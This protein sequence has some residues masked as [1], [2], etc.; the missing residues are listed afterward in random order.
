VPE[1]SVWQQVDH[2]I[3]AKT[4]AKGYLP[5][6]LDS[7]ALVCQYGGI[8]KIV[9][10]SQAGT[11]QGSGDYKP[12]GNNISEEVL[13]LMKKKYQDYDNVRE[14]YNEGGLCIF[15]FEGLGSNSGKGNSNLFPDG[16][17]GAMMVVAIGDEVQFVTKQAST[18]PAVL[19]TKSE[20]TAISDDGVYAIKTRR[21]QDLYAAFQCSTENGSDPNIP[22]TRTKMNEDNR[23]K[24]TAIGVNIH[25]APEE[26][27]DLYSTACHTI[28]SED[29]IPFLKAT[30]CVSEN[31]S[32]AYHLQKIYDITSSIKF[33][34]QN[35][36]PTGKQTDWTDEKGQKYSRNKYGIELFPELD[37]NDKEAIRLANL[38]RDRWVKARNEKAYVKDEVTK[39]ETNHYYYMELLGG[40]DM[41]KDLAGYYVVDRSHMP[42]DQKRK[43]FMIK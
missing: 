25:T 23:I 38:T 17:Y 9:E 16:R 4:C 3:M 10:V 41:K 7:A 32:M 37:K 40:M 34:G 29:Y 14:M 2:S 30:G 15:S 36:Y 6:L 18:L 1:G 24:D 20:G 27:G 8:I 13:A 39:A 42:D 12:N 5:L 22:V 31:D 11:T 19:R 43:F 33:R 21:H 35:A 26:V 28:R